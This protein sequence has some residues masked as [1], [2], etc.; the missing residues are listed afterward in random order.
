MQFNM[1]FGHSHLYLE[2]FNFL[3]CFRVIYACSPNKYKLF[4]LSVNFCKYLYQ[5]L[6]NRLQKNTCVKFYLQL[7]NF[8]TED[9]YISCGICFIWVFDRIFFSMNLLFLSAVLF[10]YGN[11]FVYSVDI[12]ETFEIVRIFQVLFFRKFHFFYFKIV[13]GHI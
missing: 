8:I 5:K 10:S 3:G 11:D 12:S 1:Y 6:K 4:S 7:S 9:V 2:I 13:T